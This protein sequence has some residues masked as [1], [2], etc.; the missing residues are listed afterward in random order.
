MHAFSARGNHVLHFI[1]GV[2]LRGTMSSFDWQQFIISNKNFYHFWQTFFRAL[3][4]LKNFGFLIR[5]FD[6]RYSVTEISIR[7]DFFGKLIELVRRLRCHFE[8]VI[9]QN[10]CRQHFTDKTVNEITNINQSTMKCISD[11][12]SRSEICENTIFNS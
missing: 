4:F 1:A 11:V 9:Y 5:F 6:F 2:C 8:I 10:H 3:F 12:R 7:L